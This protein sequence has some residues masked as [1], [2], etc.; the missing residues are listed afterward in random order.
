FLIAVLVAVEAAVH[1]DQQAGPVAA[2]MLGEA[3]GFAKHV[4][5]ALLGL[6]LIEWAAGLL[7]IHH[8]TVG[9]DPDNVIVDGAG[10]AQ[11]S[12]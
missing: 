6:G 9:A 5:E 11:R 10:A 8:Q 3:G 1:I 12:V 7:R 2:V 4:L